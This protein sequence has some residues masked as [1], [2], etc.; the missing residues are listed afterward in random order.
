MIFFLLTPPPSH[1]KKTY[2][3]PENLYDEKTPE[4]PNINSSVK[5]KNQ[6]KFLVEPKILGNFFADA[7]IF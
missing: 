1:F 6:S 4:I 3:K 7:V 2:A 5:T